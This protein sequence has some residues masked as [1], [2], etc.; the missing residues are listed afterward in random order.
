ML[1]LNTDT[2]L[3]NTLLLFGIAGLIAVF[4]LIIA[5]LR[6]ICHLWRQVPS[7][8]ERAYVLGLFGVMVGVIMS[9]GFNLDA[10]TVLP[11]LPLLIMGILDRIHVLYI[12]G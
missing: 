4:V 1:A 9:Y 7:L 11:I 2:G 12:E 6:Q 3:V 8:R 10:F 5:I